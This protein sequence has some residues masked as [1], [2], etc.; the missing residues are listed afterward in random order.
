MQPVNYV[1]LSK[2]IASCSPFIV[3]LAASLRI[4]L[5]KLSFAERDNG[6]SYD[7]DTIPYIQSSF[8][9]S[10]TLKAGRGM[11][12]RHRKGWVLISAV[13]LR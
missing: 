6:V 7:N 8:S 5:F 2:S 13:S 11:K 9:L 10:Q 4:Q 1:F 12:V 3:E